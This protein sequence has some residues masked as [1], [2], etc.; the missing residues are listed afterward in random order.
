MQRLHLP[1][2]ADLLRQSGPLGALPA[3][4]QGWLSWLSAVA[5][6]HAHEADVWLAPE[7]PH[8]AL[9]PRLLPQ[10]RAKPSSTPTVDAAGTYLITGGSGGLGTALVSWLL[11]EQRVP[12][13]QIV[14]LSRRAATP[15]VDGVRCVA[16]DL[17]RPESLDASAALAA[18]TDVRGIF[19]L[20]GVLD[21]GLIVNMTEDRLAKVVA[22]KAGL[23][24]LLAYCARRRLAPAVGARRVVDVVAPRLRRPVELLRGQRPPRLR[25]HLWRARR[26]RRR[27]AAAASRVGRELWAVGRGRHGARGDE[28]AS[29]LARVG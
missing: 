29:A 3:V 17:G 28:G 15:P 4:R 10:P 18:V 16:A 20:A 19:H 26:R 25:R 23:L 24:A 14:L 22:P 27:R 6:A 12:P 8:A 21:D 13:H 9:A 2:A 11:Q 1:A 5:S 7:A